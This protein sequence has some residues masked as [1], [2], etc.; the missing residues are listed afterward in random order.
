[1]VTVGFLQQADHLRL[2]DE[3]RCG[4]GLQRKAVHLVSSGGLAEGS[5]FQHRAFVISGGMIGR[6]A[7][8]GKP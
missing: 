6:N 8:E 2:E 4:L 5:V 1:V 3:P 7:E